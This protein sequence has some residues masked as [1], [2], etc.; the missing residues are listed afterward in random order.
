MFVSFDQSTSK[1]GFVLEGYKEKQN[2]SAF[3]FPLQP[4]TFI[5][6]AYKRYKW[7]EVVLCFYLFSTII[8]FS[9]RY[10]VFPVLTKNV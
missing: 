5:S 2:E 10:T 9:Y 4:E 7:T 6:K 8:V 1:G 3:S